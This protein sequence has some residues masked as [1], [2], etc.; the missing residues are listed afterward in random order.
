MPNGHRLDIAKLS[1]RVQ[2]LSDSLVYI[3]RIEDFKKLLI[4][5]K[6]PGWT[7]PAEFQFALGI[8]DGML[9]QVKAL[10]QMKDALIRGSGAVRG[11]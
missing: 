4:V 11:A 10:T 5:L 2:A 1:K 7:T 9:G 6:R 8:V 3:S